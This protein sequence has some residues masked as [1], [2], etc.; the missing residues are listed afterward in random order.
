MSGPSSVTSVQT[1]E[2]VAA[3]RL[4]GKKLV[5]KR[6]R[7]PKVKT[8]GIMNLRLLKPMIH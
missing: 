5:H 7:R 3:K 4:V 6:K 1:K 2:R 8:A